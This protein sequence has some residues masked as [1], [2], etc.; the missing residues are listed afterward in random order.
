MTQNSSYFAA[1]EYLLLSWSSI[2]GLFGFHALCWVC[3]G[4]FVGTWCVKD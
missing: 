2:L 1:F 4:V 3:N